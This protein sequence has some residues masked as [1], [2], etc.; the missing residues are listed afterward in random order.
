MDERDERDP[1]GQGDKSK[2][3]AAAAQP[4]PATHAA[5]AEHAA[6]AARPPLPPD[7]TLRDL[8]PPRFLPEVP[9]PRTR[10]GPHLE[11][12]STAPLEMTQVRVKREDKDRFDRLQGA[13]SL[14][15]RVPPH[16]EV[17]GFLLECA[18]SQLPA[19]LRALLDASGRAS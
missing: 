16:W 10:E 5:P 18:E 3:D 13:L 15:G 1:A 6:P 19:H 17:F 12:T 4:A 11:R 9:F 14:A 8:L 7:L 2:H